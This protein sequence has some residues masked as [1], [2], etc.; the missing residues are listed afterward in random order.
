M[1]LF[2]GYQ[3]RHLPVFIR[4]LAYSTVYSILTGIQMSHGCICGTDIGTKRGGTFRAENNIQNIIV[5]RVDIIDL[6][7]L[8]LVRMALWA[9]RCRMA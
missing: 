2:I 4:M 3:H 1:T 8:T 9:P 6:E 7:F 5:V